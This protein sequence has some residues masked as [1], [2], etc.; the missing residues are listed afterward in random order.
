MSANNPFADVAAT[1]PDDRELVLRAQGGDRDALERLITRHQ[2]WIYNIVRR[3]LYWPQDSEDTTQ[4]ILIKV[5]TKLSTFEARSSFRTWL[6]RVVVNHVLNLQR[7]KSEGWDF[8]RYKVTLDAMP[9]RELPDPNVIPA[10]IQLVVEEAKIGCTTGVLLCLDREQRLI[11]VLSEIFGATDAVGAELFEI[12]RENFRQK[13][14][15]ARRDL[16]AF[17]NNQCGLVN[18]ANPCR[19]AKKTHAFMQAGFVNPQNLLF[20]RERVIRVRD[21]AEKTLDSLDA[22]QTTFAE[23]H[24]DHPFHEPPDFVAALRSLI[25][26]ANFKSTLELE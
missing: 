20:A 3:M 16:H 18:S 22:L 10:D 6:Y 13:L 9:D 17:L 21:V 19:C 8:A 26:G 25:D 23:V 11:Y 14:S 1:D 4:E 24:R 12:T 15:R 5:I 2:A 7:R